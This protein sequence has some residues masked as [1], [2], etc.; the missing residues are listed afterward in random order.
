M[1]VKTDDG[2][3]TVTRTLYRTDQGYVFYAP[4]QFMGWTTGSFWAIRDANAEHLRTFDTF[5]SMGMATSV[6]DL[7]DRQDQGGGM[8][9]VNTIAADRAGDVL[10]ADHS[11]IPQRHQRRCRRSA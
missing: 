11:V 5:L 3:E 1:P 4:S 9:W 2:V 8:P 7:L 6:R 10:Y